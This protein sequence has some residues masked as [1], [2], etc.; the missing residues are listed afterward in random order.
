MSLGQ[1]TYNP[2]TG[3]PEAFKKGKIF[4]SAKAITKPIK[5]VVGL[6]LLKHWHLLY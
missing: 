5:N 2:I 6:K 3:L 1:L 4:K